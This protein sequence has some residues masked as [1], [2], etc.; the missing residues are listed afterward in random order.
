MIQYNIKR[1]ILHIGKRTGET[2]YYAEPIRQDR[3]TPEQVENRIINST[4]LSRADIR[5]AVTALAEVI[6]EEMF[7]GRIVDLA[8]LGSFKVVSMGKRMSK[9]EDVTVE[10]LNRP[11]ITFY[12]KAEMR[13]QASAVSRIVYNKKLKKKTTSTPAKPKPKP[14]PGTGGGAP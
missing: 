6:R 14:T 8:D 7:A 9:E 11:H 4:A 5:A 10:T 12:P 13:R 2:V 3:I 1:G